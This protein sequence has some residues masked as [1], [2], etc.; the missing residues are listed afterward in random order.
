MTLSVQH[1]DETLKATI[2]YLFTEGNPHL[3]TFHKFKSY[4]NHIISKALNIHVYIPFR[5]GLSIPD[6]KKQTQNNGQ[7]QS[8][9]K[10]TT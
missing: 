4:T 2:I 6:V 7:K 8:Q 10:N 3:R 1:V 5:S 9:I